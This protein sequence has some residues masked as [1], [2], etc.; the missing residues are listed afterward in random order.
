MVHLSRE[1]VTIHCDVPIEF[2]VEE[3][4]RT[5]MDVKTLRIDFQDLEMYS[6]ITQA[7]ELGGNGNVVIEQPVKQYHTIS[8]Q[9]ELVLLVERLNNSDLISFDL[10]TTSIIPL[11]AEIVGISFAI[12]GQ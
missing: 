9:K 7:E 6:L 10:E 3:F 5:D 8:K 1:L 12:K 4:V 2:H 11:E